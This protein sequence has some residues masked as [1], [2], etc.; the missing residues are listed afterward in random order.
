MRYFRPFVGFLIA[1]E[2]GRNS[3]GCGGCLGVVFMLFV[4]YTFFSNIPNFIDYI[5]Q[6]PFFDADFDFGQL[7]SELHG[8]WLITFWIIV[9]LAFILFIPILCLALFIC[10]LIIHLFILIY[11]ILVGTIFGHSQNTNEK[12]IE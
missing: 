5:S 7:Y 8:G 12:D 2:V 4:A 6:A 1:R 3:S 9:I 11:R 10:I